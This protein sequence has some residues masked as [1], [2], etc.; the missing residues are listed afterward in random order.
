MEKLL[1]N[2]L[3]SCGTVRGTSKGLAN[4]AE[5][6]KSRKTT[7]SWWVVSDGLSVLYKKRKKFRMKSNSPKSA[8][9]CPSK[10][11]N[12][13]DVEIA[14]L[15]GK[16][17]AP[18]SFA[19]LVTP[20]FIENKLYNKYII[21]LCLSFLWRVI[22]YEYSYFMNFYFSVFIPACNMRICL[23]FKIPFLLA[24]ITN[25]KIRLK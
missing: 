7:V 21:H 18:D 11:P 12:T 16:R 5:K 19:L 10:T 25:Q 20:N 23:L 13:D 14:V 6:S 9:T 22:L 15:K 8:T 24:V 17:S 2:N 1:N 3:F 4:H